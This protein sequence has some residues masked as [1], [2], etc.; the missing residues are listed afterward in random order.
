[1]NP[2]I[3]CIRSKIIIK[4]QVNRS[5]H[6]VLDKSICLDYEN[7]DV[8]K[9][10]LFINQIPVIDTYNSSKGLV[11]VI[12]D[13]VEEDSVN[14]SVNFDHRKYIL[15][16]LSSRYLILSTLKKYF[17]LNAYD[18]KTYKNKSSFKIDKVY[19]EDTANDI[20]KMLNSAINT[21]IESGLDV[22]NYYKDKEICIKIGYIYDG[23]RIFPHLRNLAEIKSFSITDYEFTKNGI[24]I[25]YNN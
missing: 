1:M 12:D 24:T 23:K 15:R 3:N 6:L 19:F 21:Y 7:I 22:D 2:Y 17:K 13:I 8:V 18:F 5:T 11:Y 9:E 10:P 14:L 20:I 25:Y 4:K 16:S